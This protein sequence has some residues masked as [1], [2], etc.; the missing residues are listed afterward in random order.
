MVSSVLRRKEWYRD[1][2][3][4][5]GHS[6]RVDVPRALDVRGWEALTLPVGRVLE[7]HGGIEA[8]LVDEGVGPVLHLL[9]VLLFFIVRHLPQVPRLDAPIPL[10][11]ILCDLP[12]QLPNS[13]HS[14][15]YARYGPG[16]QTW[17]NI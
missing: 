4:W 1:E 17:G 2:T 14:R 7:V 8:A 11:M 3:G 5:H 13:S 9:I 12:S 16:C 6:N 10:H 15:A